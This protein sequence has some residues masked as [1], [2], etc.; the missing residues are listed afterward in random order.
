MDQLER[1]GRYRAERYVER[2][3]FDAYMRTG[4]PFYETIFEFAQRSGRYVWRTRGDGRVRLSHAKNE[5]NVISWEDPPS[6]GHPGEDYNCR[7]HASLFLPGVTEYAAHELQSDLAGGRGLKWETADFVSH[8]YRGDGRA[9]DLREIWH[10]EDVAN[11]HAYLDRGNG[12]FRRLSDQIA[13]EARA[14]GVGNLGFGNRQTYD[15]GDVSFAHGESTVAYRFDGEVRRV[16]EMLRI[17]GRTT[18]TFKD[19]FTDPLDLRQA[20]RIAA[21]PFDELE[22]D[23]IQGRLRDLS[24]VGGTPYDIVGTWTSTFEGDIL[25]DPSTSLYR[26]ANP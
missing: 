13:Y 23:D 20:V 1:S 25:V 5:G 17:R 11:Q 7:C 9:I 8:F 14:N 12:A 26:D 4:K 21:S 15:F 10:L 16:G 22:D 3:A 19:T 2:Q 24:E 6:T 18:F